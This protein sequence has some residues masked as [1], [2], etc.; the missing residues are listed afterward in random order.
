MPIPHIIHQTW[1]THTVPDKW[2]SSSEGWKNLCQENKWQYMLWSDEDNYNL[3]A[4]EYD[5]FLEHYNAYEH[6]IQ[7]ADAVRYFILHKHGGIYVD[8]DMAPIPDRF[9]ALFNMFK[10]EDVVLTECTSGNNSKTQK[11]TNSFM[12]SAPKSDFWPIVWSY[13]NKPHKMHRWKRLLIKWTYYFKIL[14]GTGPG[15]ICDAARE[16]GKAYIIPYQFVL[17]S[18]PDTNEACVTTLMGG[19][20]HGKDVGFFHAMKPVATNWQLILIVLFLILFLVFMS[21]YLVQKSKTCRLP[22][23]PA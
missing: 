15:V 10:N 14:M 22:Q 8:L 13:L 2:L 19:S 12:G 5:W 20:W 21:M 17:P 23:K 1:K 3:I 4:S 18:G 16:Y 11:L 9:L 6:N 7:R